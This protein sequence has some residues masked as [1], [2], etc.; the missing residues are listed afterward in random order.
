M[1]ALL[2]GP[3]KAQAAPRV[4]LMGR[5]ACG[6]HRVPGAGHSTSMPCDQAGARGPPRYQPGLRA[7][8]QP[9]LGLRRRPLEVGSKPVHSAA[10][11]IPYPG[12]AADSPFHTEVT[13]DLMWGVGI[14]A[15]GSKCSCKT[16]LGS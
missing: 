13:C 1:S 16:P 4:V 12:A 5:P 3:C 15:Q 8:L 10:P 11:L 2:T 14:K 9:Q 6:K 7:A